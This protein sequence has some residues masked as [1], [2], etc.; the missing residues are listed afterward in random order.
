M[1]TSD[2]QAPLEVQV[3]QGQALQRFFVALSQTFALACDVARTSTLVWPGGSITLPARQARQLARLLRAHYLPEICVTRHRI[4]GGEQIRW[5]LTDCRGRII[6]DSALDEDLP[7][8]G[9]PVMLMARRLWKVSL[10]NPIADPYHARLQSQ[11]GRRRQAT[12]QAVRRLQALGETV[13]LGQIVRG[14]C[15]LLPF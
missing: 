7:A 9:V 11:S 12:L 3:R 4:P 15:D 14:E 13:E 5:D 6:S 2:G 1:G 8:G 10:T